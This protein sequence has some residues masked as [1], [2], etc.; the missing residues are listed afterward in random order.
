MIK[1]EIS[2]IRIIGFIEIYFH[3]ASLINQKRIID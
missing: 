2:A 1:F 3:G